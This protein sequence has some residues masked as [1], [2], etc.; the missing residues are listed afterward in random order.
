MRRDDHLV[1]FDVVQAVDD[2][3]AQGVQA[4][5]FLGVVDQAAKDEGFVLL[6]GAVDGFLTPKQKPAAW[7]MVILRGMG[8]S[9]AR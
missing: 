3:L 5:D 6:F 2:V 7:A 4:G 8:L 9:W 1:A